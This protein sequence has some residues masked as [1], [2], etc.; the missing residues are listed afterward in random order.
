M[1]A[2]TKREQIVK[3]PV[4]KQLK[5]KTKTINTMENQNPNLVTG[6]FRDKDSAD[7]A[8]S[9]LQSKGYSNNDIHL[10]MSDDTRKKHYAH[11]TVKT[12]I[13]NK[14]ME[15]AGTGSAIGGT[16]GAIAGA[17]AAIGT[18]LLLPGL[19]LVIAGPLAAAA[20][21]A[22][23]GGASGGIIGALVGS[24]IPKE[25]AAV[26]ENGVK[27]GNIVMGVNARDTADADYIEKDWR[28]NNVEELHR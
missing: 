22:G 21:G 14:A 6:M 9:T 8:Y 16:V 12:D 20:A 25:R 28:T 17:V 23:I 1:I 4:K 24:G 2:K 13:G 27:D 15:G 26:Y 10:I 18:T 5:N 11:E 7:R 19:G 3:T